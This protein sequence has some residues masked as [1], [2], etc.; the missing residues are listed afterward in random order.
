MRVWEC[1]MVTVAYV[2]MEILRGS[3]LL[4]SLILQI[5]LSHNSRTN[6]ILAFLRL[7]A[8]QNLKHMNME[9]RVIKSPKGDKVKFAIWH[10][11]RKHVAQL[12]TAKAAVA[13]MIKG[14]LVG[15][16][17]K[18]R[19]VYAHF[20]I[21]IIIAGDAQSAE[22]RNFLGC[23]QVFRVSMR[24]GVTIKED[25]TAKDTV[26]VEGNDLDEVSQ[27]AAD[28]HGACLP[29]IRRFDIRKF[30]DGVY[31]QEKTTIVKEDE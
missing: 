12:R 17:Y 2:Y 15:W 29:A 3:A 20:P 30:L 9:M 24:K 10:G 23:K 28:L 7:F 11:G 21:N 19:A 8:K 26:L 16:Q 27:S 25:K 1:M 22:V 4:D 6:I 18:M 31:C 14:L 13:N 5:R